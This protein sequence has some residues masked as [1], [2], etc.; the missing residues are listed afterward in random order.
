[1]TLEKSIPFSHAVK[2]MNSLQDYLILG[3]KEQVKILN[4]FHTS[5]GVDIC[6]E[7]QEFSEIKTKMQEDEKDVLLD[8]QIINQHQEIR[9]F[10][11]IN[12][13]NSAQEAIENSE[14]PEF[15]CMTCTHIH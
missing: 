5:L 10:L 11:L 7:T 2:F 1:M 14:R 6:F 8:M 4:K 13:S 12:T 3:F 15:L 9:N